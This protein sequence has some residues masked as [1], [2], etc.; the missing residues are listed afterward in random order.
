MDIL[1]TLNSGEFWIKV[2]G[3]V[4][5]KCIDFGMAMFVLSL[6]P[7]W[8]YFFALRP[9]NLH[10]Q[11]ACTSRG[12]HLGIAQHGELSRPHTQIYVV[13]LQSCIC[14]IYFIYKWPRTS[15]L[16]QSYMFIIF[17][18]SFHE[19]PLCCRHSDLTQE[20]VWG[21]RRDEDFS[22]SMRGLLLLQLQGC[23]MSPTVCMNIYIYIYTSFTYM[24]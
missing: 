17:P 7:I 22:G 21:R 5:L 12:P 10:L 19:V 15:N 8:W 11:C 9:Q 4:F 14:F 13:K 3:T 23:N 1:A 16:L 20:L 6:F 24:I 18:I 2:V